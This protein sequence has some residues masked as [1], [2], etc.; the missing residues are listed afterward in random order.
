MDATLIGVLAMRLFL[1]DLIVEPLFAQNVHFFVH[2]FVRFPE[3]CT[4]YPVAV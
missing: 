1:D 2:F 4:F 3:R